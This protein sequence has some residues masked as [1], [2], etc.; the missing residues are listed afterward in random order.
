MTDLI[1]V[2]VLVAFFSLA[3]LF[4]RACDHLVGEE[5]E[6]DTRADDELAEAA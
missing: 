6:T 1:F 2:A 3:A 5:V 4:V